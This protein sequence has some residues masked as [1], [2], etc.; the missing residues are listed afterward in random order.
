MTL[1]SRSAVIWDSDFVWSF[2]TTPTA[3]IAALLFL[4]LAGSALLAPWIAPQNPFDLRQLSIMDSNLP[5]VWTAGSDARFLLGT[6]DQGRD[7]LSAIL[8]GT[9][10]SLT[11]GLLAVAVSATIG[12]LLGAVSGY[13]GGRLDA[14]LMRV[15]D[16]QLTFPAILVALLIDGLARNILP[17]DRHGEIAL[18]VIIF[19]IAASAWVQYA[20]TVR[21]SV[22]AEKT[23][24]YIQAAQVMGMGHM[25]IL[26]R[27][28]LP[29]VMGPVLVIGTINLALAIMIEASLSFL[30]VGVP[31]TTPSLGT[32]IRIGNQYLFSGEWWI[33]IFP[34]IALV[35]L[36][37]SVNLLGD[38]LRDTLNPR[39]ET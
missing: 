2:R 9:R 32:L 21:S 37:L 36:A 28:I 13:V 11:V 12:V 4:G 24:E 17:S 7:L 22:M 38:W 35:L 23:R 27:H 19:A 20:R 34:G 29:N 3:W 15:A 33:A 18:T 25:R 10:I 1:F 6:D 14:V 31:P 30:G 26:F 16:I 8:Y 5:P 39:L